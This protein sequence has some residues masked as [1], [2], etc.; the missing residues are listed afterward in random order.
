MKIVTMKLRAYYFDMINI[1][2][3]DL[4]Q[5]KIDKKSSKNIIIYYIAYITIKNLSYTK[6]NSVIPFYFIIDKA[7]RYIEES[8]GNKYLTL[9]FTDKNK[10]ILKKYTE[11]ME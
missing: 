9:V 8:N 4:N 7:D 1:K 5:I 3:F 6:I 10:D 2:K 11:L